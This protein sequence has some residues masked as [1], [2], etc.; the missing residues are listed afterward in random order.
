MRRLALSLL[1]ILLA[2]GGLSAATT[3]VASAAPEWQ[4][5]KYDADTIMDCQLERPNTGVSANVGWLSPTGQVPKVGQTFY[6][7]GYAGLVGMPCSGGVT[8]IPK[9][10]LPKGL[11]FADGDYKWD[12]QAEGEAQDMRVRPFTY[13]EVPEGVLIGDENGDPFEVR[14]GGIFEFQFPVRATRAMKGNATR[15]PECRLRRDGDGPCPLAESGDHFQVGFTVSGHGGDKY[16]VTP[17]VPIF[18][19]GASNPGGPG[20]PGQPGKVG[21]RT[22]ATFQ[23]L[24][25]RRIR[26]TV[27]VSS[28][29][30]ATGRVVVLDKGKPVARGVLKRGRAVVKLPRLRPGRHQLVAKYAGSARVKASAS[31]AK[32]IR[33]R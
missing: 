26:A 11:E 28:S 8:I 14:Q 23:V 7:R 25:G 29:V 4:D 32:A 12:V 13:D 3:P 10:V 30:A 2:G 19:A 20:Q 1:A 31:R 21:S 33:L 18:T 16:F 6:V 17:Y 15:A 27:K 9:L 5:G 24:K 22:T